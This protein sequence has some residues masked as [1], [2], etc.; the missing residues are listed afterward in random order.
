MGRRN[1]PDMFLR[2]LKDKY[3]RVRQI[4]TIVYWGLT[5]LSVKDTMPRPN[6]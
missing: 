1:L 2:V 3:G 4:T 6:I 5:F